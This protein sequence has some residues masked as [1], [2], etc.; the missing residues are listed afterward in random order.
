[1]VFIHY[2]IYSLTRLESSPHVNR[3]GLIYWQVKKVFFIPM[4]ILKIQKML[5]YFSTH[6]LSLASNKNHLNDAHKRKAG[7]I[8]IGWDRH[9]I[10]TILKAL[11]KIRIFITKSLKPNQ[12][13]L[14][15]NGIIHI[16]GTKVFLS[17]FI[18]GISCKIRNLS[19]STIW[20]IWK[21]NSKNISTQK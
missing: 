18:P 13:S 1:M 17:V 19:Q 21:S 12:Y 5:S 2:V 10:G 7:A 8:L 6:Y 9:H 16:L 15:P 3:V 11:L 14:N 20:T 4:A